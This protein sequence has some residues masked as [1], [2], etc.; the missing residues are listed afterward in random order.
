MARAEP[1]AARSAWT[2]APP[3]QPQARVRLLGDA[4][5][6]ACP[7][8]RNTTQRH[9]ATLLCSA[10]ST[11][12]PLIRDTS[13]SADVPPKSTATFPNSDIIKPSYALIKLQTDQLT[14]HAT[15]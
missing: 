15:D 9:A 6:F 5:V 11:P 10:A 3:G 1:P 4:I 7:G 13:R 8:M 12:A 2:V 14:R